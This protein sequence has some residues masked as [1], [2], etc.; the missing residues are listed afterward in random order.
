MKHSKEYLVLRSSDLA[1]L[2]GTSEEEL[3]EYCGSL[4][5]SL[6]FR[7]REL[8]EGERDALILS[9]LEKI[10]SKDL[11]SAGSARK[12]DWEHGWQENLT[13][14]VQS[15]FDLK[16]LLP[17]YYKKNVPVRL[18]RNYVMPI[19]EDF[20]Y[21]VTHVFRSWLFQRYFPAVDAVHEFGC[22]TAHHL[23]YLASIYP[24]KKFYGYDWSTP[25]QEI[26]KLLAQH[27]GWDIKG[28]KFDFFCPSEDIVL[29]KNCGV[30]TFGALEQTGADHDKYIDFLLKQAPEICINVECL[31]E[32]YDTGYLPDYLALKYHRK[33]NYLSGYLTRLRELV[34]H[35]K[36]EIIKVH[37]QQF[38]NIFDDSHS[39]VIWKPL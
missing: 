12:I 2:F 6:D 38:G 26:I 8:S 24:Q 4:I 21:N 28:F 5:D 36:I 3:Q 39:Y 37:H 32:L 19:S 27:F 9:V 7:Y 22:G 31:H 11:S 10:D 17:K 1:I 15:G 33:R 35:G 18:Q 29:G 23:A 34:S 25:S 14:F 20:V 16:M 13:A 30:L